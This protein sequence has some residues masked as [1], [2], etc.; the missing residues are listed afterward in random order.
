MILS[1]LAMK[2]KNNE[3]KPTIPISYACVMLDL[4][5]LCAWMCVCIPFLKPLKLRYWCKS[6]P[7]N[8]L[9]AVF[10]TSKTLNLGTMVSQEV[11]Q[12]GFQLWLSTLIQTIKKLLAFKLSKPQ[13]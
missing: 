13:K 4:M 9:I 11:L 10:V 5:Y 7:D 6:L 1:E 8:Q 2:I 3:K 12:R